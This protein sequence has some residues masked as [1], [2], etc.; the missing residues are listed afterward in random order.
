MKQ[1]LYQNPITEQYDGGSCPSVAA[2]EE[3]L[4]LIGH[5]ES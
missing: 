3:Q 4:E 2:K 5:D 1:T